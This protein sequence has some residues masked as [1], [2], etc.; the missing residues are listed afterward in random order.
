MDDA[1]EKC[2]A[3]ADGQVLQN[4]DPG[5]EQHPLPADGGED[6]ERIAA[7]DWVRQQLADAIPI[8]GTPAEKYLVIRRR[9]R[10]PW[11]EA[12]RWAPLSRFVAPSLFVGCS[13]KS[14]GRDHRT[15]V[16]RTRPSAGDQDRE[17]CKAK[18]LARTDR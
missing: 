12:L 4:P 17:G 8:A 15:A 2:V 1:L 6:A 5:D 7:I 3:D 16:D 10:G 18:A 11:P 9:L 13:D 14:S